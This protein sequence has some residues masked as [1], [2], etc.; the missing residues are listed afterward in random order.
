MTYF[1]TSKEVH[2]ISLWTLFVYLR[3]ISSWRS[4][5]RPQMY[6]RTRSTRPERGVRG[7]W[8]SCG[9]SCRKREQSWRNPDWPPKSCRK[10][11]GAHCLSD[12]LVCGVNCP[13]HRENK[14]RHEDGKGV[15]SLCFGVF[16]L[17]LTHVLKMFLWDETETRKC[18][19]RDD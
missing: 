4:A 13:S 7:S 3:W 16:L 10:R 19:L 12:S 1:L 15:M 6:F 9:D 8:T 18:R 17:A 5:R 14:S 11:C 2:L